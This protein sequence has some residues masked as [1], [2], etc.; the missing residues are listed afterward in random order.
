MTLINLSISS[1]MKI[2]CLLELRGDLCQR[3]ICL[4]MIACNLT[5]LAVYFSDDDGE[6]S[7]E[8]D[9]DEEGQEAEED[10][11]GEEEEGEVI[12][13]LQVKGTAITPTKVG[14]QFIIFMSVNKKNNFFFKHF[15]KLS[16][17]FGSR[18]TL[19]FSKFNVLHQNQ[20]LT[21]IFLY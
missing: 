6:L 20:M 3:R 19:G 2:F 1:G 4:F 7:D 10:E 5:N 15:H 18:V 17:L 14:I 12:D 11:P 9:E 16:Y 13:D 8:E 21:E